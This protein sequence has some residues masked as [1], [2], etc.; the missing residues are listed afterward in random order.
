MTSSNGNIFRVTGLL[1]GEFTGPRHKGQWRGALMLPL[2]CVWTN[3]WVNN[4]DAGD[5]RRYRVHYDVTVMDSGTCP[6][7]LRGRTFLNSLPSNTEQ[8]DN[9]RRQAIDVQFIPR[10]NVYSRIT[11]FLHDDVMK[12]KHFPRYWPFERGIHRSPVNSPHKGQWRGALMFSLICAWIDGSVNTGEACDLRRH[13]AHYDVT[14][15]TICATVFHI[16]ALHLEV[17]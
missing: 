3:A 7:S 12:W 4:R 5:L 2:I 13:R 16:G 17:F 1:C 11:Q 9:D 15:F 10:I 8:G 6:L 14:L